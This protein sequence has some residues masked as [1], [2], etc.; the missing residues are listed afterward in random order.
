VQWACSHLKASRCSSRTSRRTA[1][2]LCGQC[3]KPSGRFR[4]GSAQCVWPSGVAAV[5]LLVLL[6]LPMLLVLVLVL[7]LVLLP[8]PPPPPSSLAH[9]AC[10]NA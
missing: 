1:E 10:C 9:A 3:V 2:R 8:P 6:V 5:P 7:V 4:E